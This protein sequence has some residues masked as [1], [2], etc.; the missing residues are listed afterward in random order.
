MRKKLQIIAFTVLISVGVYSQE[1]KYWS[2]NPAG[3]ME[4]SANKTVKR[5]SFPEEFKL[6]NLNSDAFKQMLYASVSSK[7]RKT[8]IITLPNSSGK[9]E[10]FAIYE[11]SN[12]DPELQARFPEI[13]AFSGVGITDKTATLKLSVSPLGVQTMVFRSDKENEFMEPYSEDGKVY[14]VYNSQRK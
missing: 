4:L 14:A 11:A 1:D 2:Q 10:E 8:N 12:F 9:L 5:Q 7:N 6:F 13:R 3:K